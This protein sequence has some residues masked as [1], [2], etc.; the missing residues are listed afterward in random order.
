[1]LRMGFDNNQR[2]TEL[3]EPEYQTLSA[4]ESASADVPSSRAMEVCTELSFVVGRFFFTGAKVK[5]LALAAAPGLCY[6]RADSCSE[7]TLGLL[8]SRLH[9]T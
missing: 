2:R 1:M 7:W 8:G 5:G 6:R 4:K 3:T 9:E